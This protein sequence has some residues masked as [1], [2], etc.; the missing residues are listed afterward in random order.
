MERNDL[1]QKIDLLIGNSTF[2]EKTK[3]WVYTEK[4][5]DGVKLFAESGLPNEF[6]LRHFF[7]PYPE[8][9]CR[10]KYWEGFAKVLE[11][12]GVNKLDDVKNDVL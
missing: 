2:D 5:M 7:P 3:E 8:P 12:R 1:I 10:K 9:F 4:F 11:Y 6:F